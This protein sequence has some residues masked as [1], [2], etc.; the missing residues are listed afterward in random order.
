MRLGS[1]RSNYPVESSYRDALSVI[2]TMLIAPDDSDLVDRAFRQALDDTNHTQL[3]Y[4]MAEFH[5]SIIRKIAV[6]RDIEPEVVLQ[7]I[8][9]SVAEAI[10]SL[11]P[12][13]DS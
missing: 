6:L 1:Q 5:A 4:I 13:A 9:L 3:V 2:T 11:P 10:Q 12:K 8:A 7:E